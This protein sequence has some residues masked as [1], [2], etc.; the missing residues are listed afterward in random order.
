MNGLTFQNPE[1]FQG[2]ILLLPLVAL[3]FWA[4]RKTARQ[5]PGLV[6]P[7]LAARLISGNSRT[8]RWIVFSFQTLSFVAILTALARPQLGFDEVETETDA[9]NLILAIDTSRSMMSD[10]LPPNRLTRAKLAAKD[11]I[12]SLPDDRVGLI[13]F[14]G[15]AFVQA[16]LTVDHEAVLEA[17]DQLD[18]E[19]IPRGGTNLSAAAELAMETFKEAELPQSALVLFSDGEALEG[20]DEIEKVR[21]N[22]AKMGMAILTVGVG[23]AEGS[24]IPE[25]DANGDPIP[26]V[27]VKDEAGQV[28]RT[29]LDPKAMQALAS[30][31]G[32]YIHLGGQA[33]LTHVVEQIRRGIATSREESETRLRPVER[34]MWP[35]S[36]AL[37]C[38]LLGYV[39]PL[40]WLKPRPKRPLN[41]DS[42]RRL[43]A[44]LVVLFLAPAGVSAKDQLTHGY[45]AY[46][47]KNYQSALELYEG[48]LAERMT[49]KDRARLQMGIGAAAY[50]LGNFERASEAYGQALA[51]G[52][53]LV[54]SQAHY[55]LGNTLFKQGETRLTGSAK[56][57]DPDQVQSLSATGEVVDNTIREWENAIE[58]YN[59]TLALDPENARALH[60]REL[61]QKRLDELKKQ[62]E[63]QEKQKEEQK[64]KDEKEDKKKDE[65]EKKEDEKK[66]EKKDEQKDQDK[67]DQDQP[68]DDQKDQDKNDQDQPKDDQKGDSKD[69]KEKDP[70]EKSDKPEGEQPPPEPKPGEGQE[71]KEKGKEKGDQQPSDQPKEGKGDQK[72][73]QQQ[74]SQGQQ[75][76]QPDAPK[77]GELEANP[78]QEQP[79]NQIGAGQPSPAE[80]KQN[81]ETGYSPTEARQLLDALAD[82]TEVRPILKSAKGE[83]FKNW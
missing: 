79:Q 82:E 78:N 31:G 18:T 19:I 75:P 6:S 77:N 81:P 61:V 42:V 74:P 71:D 56:K 67:K 8:Q 27:F 66:D 58:H 52:S 24:I 1:W 47:E 28:V 57:A 37:L 64:K 30:G 17:I 69:Q 51:D 32:A 80:M 53:E 46:Q 41:P 4:H 21:A 73:D 3:R 11:I 36:I 22:A 55:N 62:K 76:E 20:S 29:R 49:Q 59:S 44:G 70:G 63:E 9:R 34:F 25:S 26:G 68:K 5:L 10:D 43:T 7:R 72:K 65:E 2:L 14:A 48:N 54:Q 45:K 40:F 33:S 15:R 38:L 83:K 50:S 60:N 23:T 16:P 13:A 12:L 35:L 39:I